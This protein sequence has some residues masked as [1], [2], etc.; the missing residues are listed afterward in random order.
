[1]NIIAKKVEAYPS[2]LAAHLPQIAGQVLAFVLTRDTVGQVAAYCGILVDAGTGEFDYD[3]IAHHGAKLTEAK[4]RER[5][6]FAE[7]Y[8]R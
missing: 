7:E 1:M 4:A 6:T 5:F 3:W 2:Q 8:R